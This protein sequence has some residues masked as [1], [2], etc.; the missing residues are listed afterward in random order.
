MQFDFLPAYAIFK[1]NQEPP[2][3]F[4]SIVLIVFTTCIG[5]VLFLSVAHALAPKPHQV[6]YELFS[7]TADG[8]SVPFG[9]YHV[10]LQKICQL[11]KYNS[12]LQLNLPQTELVQTY[13]TEEK[14]DGSSLIFDHKTEQG[15]QLLSQIKGQASRFGT[16]NVLVDMSIPKQLSFDLP[17]RTEF[18]VQ[19][20]TTL[21]TY[22]DQRAGQSD[23]IVF[24][25]TSERAV[26]I[27]TEI[28]KQV[29]INRFG[30]AVM[31][32]IS[33]YQKNSQ[34]RN[35]LGRVW[36]MVQSAYL[37]DADRNS[38]LGSEPVYQ[39]SFNLHES[40]VVVSMV[41]Q[42]SDIVLNGVLSDLSY[43]TQSRC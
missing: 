10:S 23:R 37:L 7:Q 5:M 41:I 17:I 9:T 42:L 24:E 11:W 28:K 15:Q 20:L 18:A 21:L 27:V 13:R 2:R 39:F 38:P 35:G 30:T 29:S 26:R 34:N 1:L 25:G 32:L 8:N 6:T 22:A 4:L 31:E 16:G 43:H 36:P 3:L 14:V 12:R 33:V 40:G 19:H